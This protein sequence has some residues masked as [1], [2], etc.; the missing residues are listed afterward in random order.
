MKDRAECKHE[1][2]SATV[3]VTR[4]QDSG[5]FMA[6]VRIVCDQCGTPMHFLGLPP[7]LN[8]Q[9]A[10]VSIDG[11]EARFAIAPEGVVPSPLQSL[12][13]FTISN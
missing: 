2:F 6:S 13:G 11:A 9:G 3:E 12:M 10:A 4:L 1:G 8:L 5:G 7:G